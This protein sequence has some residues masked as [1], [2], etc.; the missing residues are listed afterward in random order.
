MSD[1]PSPGSRLPGLDLS[2][3]H[4]VYR[5]SIIVG[6][7]AALLIW[8][9]FGP[10]AA[11]G[12]SLGSTLSLFA[13]AMLEWSV[14]RYIQPGAK[15]MR[16]LIVVSLAK[17]LL[18][19]VVLGLSYVAATNGWLSLLWVLPGF[20]LPH[21]IIGLKFVGQKVVATSRASARS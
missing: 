1:E 4:R 5:T 6:I 17:T 14:R 18:M 8:E 3:I 21:L 10:R 7:I 11:M 13:L 19:F 20:M 9:R 12:W 16:S 2:F 15:S